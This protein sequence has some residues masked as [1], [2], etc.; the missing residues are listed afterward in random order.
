MKTLVFGHSGIGYRVSDK[1]FNRFC[2]VIKNIDSTIDN[3]ELTKVTAEITKKGK[4]F[5][6]DYIASGDDDILCP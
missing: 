1:I 6:V 4:P 3:E 5:V 2:E